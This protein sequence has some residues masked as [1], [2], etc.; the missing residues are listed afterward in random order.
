MRGRGGFSYLAGNDLDAFQ[1][2]RDRARTELGPEEFDALR[3]RFAT[4][5][6][7]DVIAAIRAELER[8]IASD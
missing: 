8:A 5:P 3:T 4:V 6:F 1:D 7:D 2:A